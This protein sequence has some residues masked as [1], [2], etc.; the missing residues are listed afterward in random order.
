MPKIKD[1]DWKGTAYTVLPIISPGLTF[2]CATQI[3]GTK[4]FMRV[5]FISLGIASAV[6]A[7][8]LAR[9]ASSRERRNAAME[10]EA[11]ISAVADEMGTLAV[12]Q[13][14]TT[15]ELGVIENRLVTCAAEHGGS[16]AGAAFYALDDER[17]LVRVAKHLRDNA[18]RQFENRDLINLLNAIDNEGIVYIKDNDKTDG[19]LSIRLADG[20]RS[21]IVAPVFSGTVAQGVLIIDAPDPG[22][23]TRKLVRESYVRAVARLLG[24]AHAMGKSSG[25]RK[26]SVPRQPEGEGSG[27]GTP[28]TGRN[29]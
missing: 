10:M 11:V 3:A 4:G 28:T 13:D 7:P 1:I 26:P 2:F 15:H 5:V 29:D 9:L 24:T 19:N 21:A 22:K 20:N 23:L 14:D 8:F 18:P 6:L 16:K 17:R 27:Q 25:A 12:S